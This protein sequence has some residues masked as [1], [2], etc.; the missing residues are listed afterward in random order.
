MTETMYR[1]DCDDSAPDDGGV[2]PYRDSYHD[3]LDCVDA[4]AAFLAEDE[5]EDL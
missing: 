3:F 5:D 2:L 1:V 4:A